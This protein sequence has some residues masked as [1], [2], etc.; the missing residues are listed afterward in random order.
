MVSNIFTLLGHRWRLYLYAGGAHDAE[1]RMVSV[2]LVHV[3]GKDIKIKLENNFDRCIYEEGNFDFI[4]NGGKASFN[5][6]AT[7]AKIMKSLVDGT[8]FIGVAMKLADPTKVKP[9]PFIPENP[10]A[11]KNIQSMFLDEESSDV[12]FEVGGQRGKDNA[13]KVARTAPVAFHAHRFI[14]SKCS[15][16]L[17][18]MCGPVGEGIVPIQIDNVSPET[19]RLLLKYIYG[20]RIS[21]DD[22]REHTKE[23]LDAADKFG[24]TYLKLA[25]EAHFVQATSFRLENMMEHLLYAESKNCALL[26]EAVMDFIV[27]N[28]DEV[29]NTISFN[30]V[31]APVTVIKDIIAAVVRGKKKGGGISELR[32]KAHKKGLDVD[33]SREML[34]AALAGSP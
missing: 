1:Q 6:F 23:I 5:D 34:I 28:G 33:G 15:S 14:L 9:P 24:V 30:G 20:G 10:F 11:C 4:Q 8:L 18:A 13:E 21:G 19:F 25:A 3:S 29:L 32:Q 7:R 26:K 16:T 22:M 31:I 2:E 17:A 12:V 27:E